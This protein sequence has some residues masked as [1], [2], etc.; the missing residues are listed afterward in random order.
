MTVINKEAKNRVKW[1]PGCE[2]LRIT[3]KSCHTIKS[4]E[5]AGLLDSNFLLHIFTVKHNIAFLDLLH[6]VNL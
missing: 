1:T 6:S 3:L 4:C 2:N 5:L